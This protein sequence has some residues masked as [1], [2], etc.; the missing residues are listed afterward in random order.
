M[1]NHTRKLIQVKTDLQTE[2]TISLTEVAIQADLTCS[3]PEVDVSTWNGMEG[4]VT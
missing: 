1:A 2:K 4:A 3:Y